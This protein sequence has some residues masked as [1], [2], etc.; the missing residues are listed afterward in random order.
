MRQLGV[1]PE[2]LEGVLDDLSVGVFVDHVEHGCIYAS[3][4]VLRMFGIEWEAFKG[5]GWASAVLPADMETLRGA[6]DVQYRIKIPGGSTRA[7]HVVGH[8]VLDAQGTQLGSVL[9]GREVT[10]ERA[11]TDR[12]VE[13]QKLEAIGR[14]AVTA[15]V[16]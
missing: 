8:A 13:S 2:A 9:I 4:G 15:R 11:P 5:F 1:G 7:L 6:I 10:A 14:V 3:A 12:S 16:M